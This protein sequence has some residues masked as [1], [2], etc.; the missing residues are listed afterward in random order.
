MK[1]I[2]TLWLLLLAGTGAFSQNLLKG[3]VKDENGAALAG[4]LIYERGTSNGTVSAWDGAYTIRYSRNDA[5]IVFSYTGYT[6][7]DVAVNGRTE[8]DVTLREGLVIEGLEIVGSRSL[9]RTVTNSPVP[10]DVIDI[11]QLTTTQGQLDLNQVLQYAAPSFNANRQTGADG[12]DHTDPAT[13]R[14]LG[15]DQTLVLING[16]R[17]HQSSLVNIYGTRGRGNTG[18][19]LNA[20][21]SAAIERIEI[22]RDGAS[23]QYGSDAIAGVINIVL[24]ENVEEFT[25]N[26]N[27]GANLAKDNPGRST[28]DGE[29]VQVN[30]NY[31]FRV[32]QGGFVNVTTD[33]WFHG[34]TNRR[35]PNLYRRQFG[36]AKGANFATYFNASVPL[37]EKA[38]A[39]AFG[40]LNTRKT[41]AY[42]WSRDA[43]EARNVD[44]LY[45]NGFDP[46]IATDITDRS[47]SAGLRGELGGWGADFSHTFGSNRFHYYGHG[48]AN[49]SL[50]E[51]SPTDFDD[52]GF[53]LQQNVTTLDFTRFFKN[54]LAGVNL[55]FGMEHRVE[56]YQI[57]AGEEGSWK[58]YGPVFFG[59]D[60]ESGDTIYRP[61][62]AQGF[63]GFG[64][65]N[66]V[67]ESRTNLAAYLDGECPNSRSALP[68]ASKTTPISAVP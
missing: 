66:A 41:D 26:V 53:Q 63:P 18:T 33:Y 51:R 62:G 59:I 17:R 5:V 24:K 36:D 7:Q 32:G 13:L 8:L 14:G 55:A 12:A 16:K 46:I 52:G 4:V 60:T 64:P 37:N 61:G 45:P 2:T 19:D 68:P 47:A 34:Y 3:F 54:W 28:F 50:E 1:L 44:A 6:V 31:G 20:I 23:A 58:T 48:T 10:V 49:A 56:N 22:L 67:N 65:S 11:R 40:G 21:P 9:N 42:A 57:F 15:P 30:G 38:S 43:G 29:N 27:V 35:D 39:Y 25:G